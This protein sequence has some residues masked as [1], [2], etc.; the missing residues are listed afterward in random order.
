MSLWHADLNL[1]FAR[2]KDSSGQT[3]LTNYQHS[4]PLLVQKPFY[5]E[6]EVC[7][8]YLLHP[9]GGIAGCDR[10]QCTVHLQPEAQVLLTTPGATKFYRTQGQ[11]SEFRQCFYVDQNATLE[12]LPQGNIFYQGTNTLVHTHIYLTSNARFIYRD[13]AVIGQPL[14]ND[15][16]ANSSCSVK[17]WVYIDKRLV[18][19]DANTIKGQEDVDA[20]A[21]L[22]SHPYLGTM[23]SNSVSEE[24]LKKIK[25]TAGTV[26]KNTLVGVSQLPKIL[27]IRYLSNDNEEIDANMLQIWKILRPSLMHRP[28]VIPRIWQ[29]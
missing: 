14:K 3:L 4:G 16:F 26:S 18:F 19:M 1:E 25:E 24:T 13:F 17:T 29:T 15:N 12:Y 28:A 11:T 6:P 10:L 27:V 21:A 22:H 9:P 23:I 8:V 5:P 20:V 2:K 7:H